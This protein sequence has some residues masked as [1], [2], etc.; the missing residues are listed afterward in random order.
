MSRGSTP[1]SEGAL[2][3]SYR[4]RPWP[5]L[6]P[7]PACVAAYYCGGLAASALQRPPA[8]ASLFA[9]AALLYWLRAVHA[10]HA[11]LAELTDG[12]HPV[13]PGAAWFGHLIPGYNLYW[14]FA[15][16]RA[17]DGFVA[18]ERARSWVAGGAGGAWLLLSA[19]CFVLV[20]AGLG[21][22]GL[23]WVL[24]TR[25]RLLRLALD[26]IGARRRSRIGLALTGAGVGTLVPV[27][28]LAGYAAL[29]ELDLVPPETVVR[30]A[31]IHGRHTETLRR[32]GVLQEG[33]RILLAYFS[34]IFSVREGGSL[35]TSRRVIHYS[36]LDDDTALEAASYAEVDQIDVVPAQTWN[37]PTSL[38]IF[39]T[40][41]RVIQLD[42]STSDGGDQ[43][44]LRRLESL[45]FGAAPTQSSD[46]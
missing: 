21:T 28:M 45:A 10:V 43:L 39:T 25:I 24:A 37:D 32:S 31:E 41:G 34:G 38:R 23:Y 29:L 26:E 42:L 8:L 6:W 35:L 5:R 44:F 30:G 11:K 40:G 1:L 19:A 17:I 16:P 18:P 36:D 7:G 9:I 2:L 22:L 20:D 27:A 3:G 4:S 33:E 46:L 12:R 13:R 15:W 14:I